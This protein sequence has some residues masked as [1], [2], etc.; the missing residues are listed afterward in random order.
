MN[1]LSSTTR[2]G[3]T[4]ITGKKSMGF[5]PCCIR[6]LELKKSEKEAPTLPN[7]A[8]IKSCVTQNDNA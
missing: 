2:A 8:S 7:R 4:S 1:Q 5:R 6:S 3:K